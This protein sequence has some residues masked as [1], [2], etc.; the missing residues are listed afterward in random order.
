MKH[1]LNSCLQ[2][3]SPYCLA[4][5]SVAVVD[6]KHLK[7]A[8]IG[9]YPA[10]PDSVR[11][12]PASGPV[13]SVYELSNALARRGNDVSVFTHIG[14][15]YQG[16]GLLLKVGNERT[17]VTLPFSTFAKNL[18]TGSFDVISLQ[19][20]GPLNVLWR[21]AGGKRIIFSPRGLVFREKFLGF[22][23]PTRYLL[24]EKISLTT[25]IVICQSRLQR[26]IISHDYGLSCSR[27]HVIPNGVRNLFL[28]YERNESD[29]REISHDRNMILY[30]GVMGQWKG[31]DFLLESVDLLL[32]RIG[33]GSRPRVVLV[34]Q[35]TTWFRS[36]ESRFKHLFENGIVNWISP[37]PQRIL[38][39]YYRN[40]ALLALPSKL[41]MFGNV[42]L[43]AMACGTPVILSNRVGMCDLIEEGREGYI[44]AYG[45]A[46]AMAERM[47][48]LLFDA[49]TRKKMSNR[50]K[51]TAS[52]YTWDEAA[53]KYEALFKHYLRNG[54]NRDIV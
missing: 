8:V 34:G 28:K 44:V 51:E 21:I 41:E 43:E 42:A 20:M 16:R 38:K 45:D 18:A 36:L 4:I 31:L 22:I 25:P 32:K 7:I 26:D 50:A 33:D 14:L 48:A 35:T 13:N 23:H 30:A 54:S 11:N 52:H 37:Q 1:V 49:D 5:S 17:A 15:G 6:L 40:S 2:S 9:D 46:N 53:S 12:G 3:K 10:R 29:V 39:Q 19:G 24:V 47:Y 27:I